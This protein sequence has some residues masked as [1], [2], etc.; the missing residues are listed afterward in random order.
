MLSLIFR[1]G[2]NSRV[3]E[4][5]NLEKNWLHL[6]HFREKSTGF[7]MIQMKKTLMKLWI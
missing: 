6:S 5:E 4:L 7:H 3:E 1:N 2:E